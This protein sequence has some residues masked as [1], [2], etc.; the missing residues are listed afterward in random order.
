M[1]F[2]TNLCN[3]EKRVKMLHGW[4]S[5][6]PVIW[7][8]MGHEGSERGYRAGGGDCRV[9]LGWVVRGCQVKPLVSPITT[10]EYM[11]CIS[12]VS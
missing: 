7:A 5:Y 11:S 2:V 6:D 1:I 4:E 3:S 8:A 12:T 9:S 10:E